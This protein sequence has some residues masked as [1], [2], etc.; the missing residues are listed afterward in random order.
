M[1]YEAVVILVSNFVL[2]LGAAAALAG[3]QPD[4]LRGSWRNPD[5]SV[6]IRIDECGGKLCGTVVAASAEAIADAHDGGTDH[7]VGTRLFDGYRRDGANHWSGVVFVPDLGHSFSSH[8]VLID[9]DHARVA[10]CLLGRFLCQSQI[11]QRV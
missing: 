11:W 2:A 5:G 6:T 10:G 9:H 7:L 8:I 3:H 4:P 1:R